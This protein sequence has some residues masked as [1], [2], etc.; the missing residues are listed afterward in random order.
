MNSKHFSGESSSLEC[1]HIFCN[2]CWTEYF[3]TKI[4]TEGASS[5]IQ[6]PQTN[7]NVHVVDSLV[8][9][10]FAQN[11]KMISK[12]QLLVTNKF[13]LCNKLLS[14]CPAAECDFAIRATNFEKSAVTCH[15]GH[16]FCF[17]CHK[18]WHE[19]LSC[20]IFKRWETKVGDDSATAKYLN[21]YTKD[22][23]KCHTAIEKD[24]GCN[25]M[26]CR[27][28]TAEF[29]WICLKTWKNHACNT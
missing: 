3:S 11:E 25:H 26:K 27:K 28:C 4:I 24:G 22:C 12:Y 15:C 2:D 19:F 13:V 1:G 16:K 9:K 20:D 21:V 14:W 18:E 8:Y 7:C 6:C 29:C 17:A 10:I 5:N 23:P